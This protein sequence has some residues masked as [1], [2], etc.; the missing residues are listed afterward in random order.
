MLVPEPGAR[1]RGSPGLRSTRCTTAPELIVCDIS[2]YGDDGPGRPRQE[3][4]DL[5]IQS[6]S[7]FVSIT[8]SPMRRPKAGCS[9]ADIAAGMYAYS[10]ILAAL[11]RR[12]KTGAAASTLSMLEHG[13][14][15][16]YRCTTPSTARRSTPRPVPGR[17]RKT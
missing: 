16:G 7:G 8:G 14:P 9:I 17:R 6:E 4:Y 5:L 10:N 13:R 15:D 2:G 12:G 1:R 11:I 3:G